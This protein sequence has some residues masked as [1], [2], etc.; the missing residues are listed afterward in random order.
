[1]LGGLYVEA[2]SSVLCIEKNH[3]CITCL[4][5]LFLIFIFRSL[6]FYI[7]HKVLLS[8]CPLLFWVHIFGS[9]AS[10]LYR[11]FLITA[12]K[13]TFRQTYLPCLAAAN[14]NGSLKCMPRLSIRQREASLW[15]MVRLSS[16]TIFHALHS[17]GDLA[18]QTYAR[19]QKGRPGPLLASSRNNGRKAGERQ[20]TKARPQSQL[21][22][23]SRQGHMHAVLLSDWGRQTESRPMLSQLSAWPNG[24]HQ[25]RSSL[26]NVKPGPKI[27][28]APYPPGHSSWS[29]R[30]KWWIIPAESPYAPAIHLISSGVWQDASLPT[31]V[32]VMRGRGKSAEEERPPRKCVRTA[33]R[34][35]A[36]Y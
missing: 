24:A 15:G 7:L 8:P 20:R 4:D 19:H 14:L 2:S 6:E 35:V 36:F 26:L 3:L 32:P 5:A 21:R 27:Y 22:P 12:S 30:G 34:F 33:V 10:G 18:S 28:G 23:G 31:P 29:E 1:M 16:C 13:P 25:A 11:N 17:D 9:K